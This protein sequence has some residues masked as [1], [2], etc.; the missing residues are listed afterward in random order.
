MEK[1]IFDIEFKFDGNQHKG[2][3]Y[4][5]NEQNGISASWHVVLNEVFFANLS[6]NDGVWSSDEQRPF[7]LVQEVGKNIEKNQLQQ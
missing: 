6:C 7:E 4:P 5:N 1:K 2:W 3:I